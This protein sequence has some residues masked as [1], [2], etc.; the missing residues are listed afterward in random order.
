ML[1]TLLKYKKLQGYNIN[2]KIKILLIVVNKY[3]IP[4][5][6]YNSTVYCKSPFLRL[7]RYTE[8]REKVNGTTETKMK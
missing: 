4:Y 6:C 3:Y 7:N 1:K 8:E 5:F 2:T